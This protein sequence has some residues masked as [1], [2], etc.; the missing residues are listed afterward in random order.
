[1]NL[2]NQS[3]N[4][5]QSSEENALPIFFGGVL[6]N[7]G[8]LKIPELAAKA[9]NIKDGIEGNV[10]CESPAVIHALIAIDTFVLNILWIMLNFA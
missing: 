5:V 9:V 6:W 7:F 10:V 8:A 4:M 2:T 3:T 1:M